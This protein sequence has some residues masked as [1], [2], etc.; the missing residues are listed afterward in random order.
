M[1]EDEI[2]GMLP[3]IPTA[4]LV[5]ELNRRRDEWREAERS[6]GLGVSAPVSVTKRSRHVSNPMQD[7]A[8]KRWSGWPNFKAKNKNATIK[9]YFAARKA[10]KA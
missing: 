7:A 3:S 9:E 5:Q 10:G 8:V 4:M 2:K 6:L 1:N